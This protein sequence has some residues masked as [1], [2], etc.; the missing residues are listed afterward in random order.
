[1]ISRE[2]FLTHFFCSRRRVWSEIRILVQ[3]LNVSQTADFAPGETTPFANG[4]ILLRIFLES[5]WSSIF[6]GRTFL[7][8]PVLET[9]SC[10]LWQNQFNQRQL[11]DLILK[12][13]RS[14]GS[15][16][17]GSRGPYKHPNPPPTMA[18]TDSMQKFIIHVHLN[19]TNIGINNWLDDSQL[20]CCIVLIIYD[21]KHLS[22]EKDFSHL[23]Q[24]DDRSI[25][26][27]LGRHQ[28]CWVVSRAWSLH[29]C[30]LHSCSH[31]GWSLLRGACTNASHTWDKDMLQYEAQACQEDVE[32]R[33]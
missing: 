12:R 13:Q 11:N 10:F 29:I 33:L 5:G 18:F 16:S 30:S 31:F 6:L 23:I 9:L 17:S 14:L 2:K 25:C 20:W 21:I 26:G 19:N 1:M 28:C 4:Q 7:E 27:Q 22:E 8:Q 32:A 15:R 3:L 24:L